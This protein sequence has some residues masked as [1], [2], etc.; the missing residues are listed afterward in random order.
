MARECSEREDALLKK[1]LSLDSFLVNLKR[2]LIINLLNH[3]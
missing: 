2:R 1:I 3:Y